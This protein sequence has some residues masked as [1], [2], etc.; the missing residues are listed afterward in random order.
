MTFTEWYPLTTT[1]VER[2]GIA[3]P[4]AVQLRRA[5]GLVRY[6][7]GRSAMVYYLF[8]ER[9]MKAALLTHF[10]DE[11]STPGV[12]G[13]GPLWFRYLEGEN[14]RAQLTVLFDQFQARFGAPPALHTAT[15]TAAIERS[16][17]PNGAES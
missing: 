2:N 10:A 1:E 4:A 14:A 12:R 13:H 5:S 6:P 8:V 9:D 11:L 3:R 17:S 16:W 7:G 15:F